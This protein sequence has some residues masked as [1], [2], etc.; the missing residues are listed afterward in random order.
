[1]YT[2]KNAL[3]QTNANFLKI[4]FRLILYP[5][6][7]Q[8]ILVIHL[9]PGTRHPLRVAVDAVALPVASW[10]GLLAHVIRKMDLV[11]EANSKLLY[12]FDVTVHDSPAT[13]D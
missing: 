1:M 10:H 8:I 2:Y 4:N 7:I 11:P 9:R 6:N 5:L 12:A 13:A 3:T